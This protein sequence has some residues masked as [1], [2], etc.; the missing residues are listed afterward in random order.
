[1]E[2]KM[3]ARPTE[4]S[5]GQRQR[6][7]IARAMFNEPSMI[8]CDEPTGSLDRSTTAQILHLFSELQRSQGSTFVVVTHDEKVSRACTRVVRLEDGRV[9]AD[10][11]QEPQ[12]P[13]LSSSEASA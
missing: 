1:L 4:L 9:V 2:E 3:H 12:L 10:D 5:G 11:A 8:L 13:E 7:A 6:V